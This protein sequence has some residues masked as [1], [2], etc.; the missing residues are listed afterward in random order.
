M[1]L[2]D[3]DMAHFRAAQMPAVHQPERGWRGALA[4][5][6]RTLMNVWVGLYALPPRRLPPLI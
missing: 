3:F 5:F 4:A 2:N 6:Y 1:K